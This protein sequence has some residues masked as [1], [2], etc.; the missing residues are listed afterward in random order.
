MFLYTNN[1]LS[2]K[3]I[4]KVEMKLDPCLTP[5]IEVNSKWIKDLNV[6]PKRT[7]LLE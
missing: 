3:E 6:I 4:K 7:K 2:E 1:K 5:L